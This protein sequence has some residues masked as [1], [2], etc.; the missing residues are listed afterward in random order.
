MTR[1]D[2][3]LGEDEEVHEAAML[4]VYG[5]QLVNVLCFPLGPEP[6]RGYPWN[7]RIMEVRELWEK[8]CGIKPEQ[9]RV[10]VD[11]LL[12]FRALSDDD[13][14]YDTYERFTRMLRIIS[15]MAEPDDDVEGFL[16]QVGAWL[17][18]QLPEVA[19]KDYADAAV[20]TGDVWDET[21][22]ESEHGAD[23]DES[24][25]RVM[26]DEGTQTDR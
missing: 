9:Q 17:H 21:N 14:R 13:D 10:V 24:P 18:E 8:E 16:R 6:E 20:Q 15:T 3:R 7:D 19:F 1:S 2:F 26:K 22:C 23:D 5:G 25:G 12:G 11:I 4:Y